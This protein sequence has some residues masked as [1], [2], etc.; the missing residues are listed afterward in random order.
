MKLS[1]VSRITTIGVFLF[2]TFGANA[3]DESEHP[4]T[5]PGELRYKGAPI[6][7][8]LESKDVVTPGAPALTEVEFAKAKKNLLRALCRLSRCAAQGCDRQAID[9]GHYPGQGYRLPE[10]V[11]RL[12]FTGRHAEL[13]YIG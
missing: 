9:A 12:R 2:A 10:S 4:G 3:K 8:Q 11:Y 1:A 6:P 13:G 5:T 7:E